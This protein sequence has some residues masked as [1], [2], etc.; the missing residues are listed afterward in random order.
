MAGFLYFFP[1]R[2]S[3]RKAEYANYGLAD[4]LGAVSAIAGA[5][6]V[7][8]SGK[9][10]HMIRTGQASVETPAYKPDTQSWLEC[11][12]GKFWVGCDNDA[13]PGPDDLLRP[14]DCGGYPVL[15]GDGNRWSIPVARMDPDG[16]DLST[17]DKSISMDRDGKLT[18]RP[19]P[20]YNVLIDYASTAWDMFMHNFDESAADAPVADENFK[21]D[22][23]VVALACNYAVTKWEVSLLL[24]VSV[25]SQIHILLSICDWPT[26]LRRVEEGQKKTGPDSI[27]AG[28]STPDGEEG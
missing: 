19:M 8:P 16:E 4:S 5:E 9:S 6:M 28:S 11:D 14:D 21:F 3:V 1:G 20:K 15:L 23:S 24:L 26:Y 18:M 7:G 12:G 2:P 22:A 25:S 27:P 10:G 17:L 13:R